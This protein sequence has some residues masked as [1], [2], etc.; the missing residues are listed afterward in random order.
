MRRVLTGGRCA[1]V[2]GETRTDNL[3]V[4]DSVRRCKGDR[5][6]AV[7]AQISCT[8]VRRV[9]ADGIGAI[10]ATNAITRDV[11]VVEVGRSPR[12]SRMAI[13]ADI[14][15]VD[16]CQ[17]LARRVRPIVTINALVRDV[18]VIEIRRNPSR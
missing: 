12:R 13:L 5:I 9:L 1:I 2:A 17:V 4:I 6:M 14:G 8:D 7:D 16:M 11:G 3:R 10:V 15:R 18:H